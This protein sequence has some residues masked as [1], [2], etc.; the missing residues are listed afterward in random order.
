MKYA[1]KTVNGKYII[2]GVLIYSELDQEGGEVY[3]LMWATLTY[4]LWGLLCCVGGGG[5]IFLRPPQLYGETI[6]IV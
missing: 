3:S 4:N 2:Y 1:E 5:Y 6:T